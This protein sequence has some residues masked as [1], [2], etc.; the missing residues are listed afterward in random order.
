[1]IERR[2]DRLLR[3]YDTDLPELRDSRDEGAPCRPYRGRTISVEHRLQMLQES[4]AAMASA[5]QNFRTAESGCHRRTGP[6]DGGDQGRS[7]GDRE[8]SDPAGERTVLRQASK[9]AQSR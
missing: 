3:L 6:Y 4:I 8:R 2:V 7:S 1:V 9:A 5:Y